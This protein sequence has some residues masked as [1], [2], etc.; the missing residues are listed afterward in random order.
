MDAEGQDYYN[1]LLLE[2]TFS[3]IHIACG[4]KLLSDLL[5]LASRVMGCWSNKIS[6]GS[7]G[8]T[9]MSNFLL[10]QVLRYLGDFFVGGI[11]VNN[12][13]I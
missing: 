1:F 6:K 7:I 8:Y 4:R 9:G 12:N 2:G 5:C 3:G 10:K 11:I 13:S